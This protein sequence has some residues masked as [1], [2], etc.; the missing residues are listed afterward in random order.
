MADKV[1]RVP[2]PVSE[3]QIVPGI[4]SAWKKIFGKKPTMSQVGK[5]LAQIMLET[6]NGKAIF[7]NNVG[8]INWTPGFTGNYY[9]IKDSTTVG[10]NPAN[11]Q[12]YTAKMR[13][14]GSISSGIEDYLILLK[15]RAPVMQALQKGNI[16][17]FSAALASVHYYDPHIRDDYVDKSGKKV[18]G[19]TSGLSARYNSFMEKHKQGVSDPDKKQHS[20][21][22][23]D[24][25]IGSFFNRLS[26]LLDNLTKSASG[27]NIMTINKYGEEYPENSFLISIDTNNDFST[28][29]EFARI[30][31]L[32]L[33]EEIDA[34]SDIY[35]D[36]NDVE[37]QCVVNA[38]KARSL[39]VVKELC[40]AMSD[41][42]DY[43][44]KKIGGVK[45]YTCVMPDENS[46]YQKLD[47]KI[48]ETNYRIFKIKFAQLGKGEK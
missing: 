35:T 28:K 10:N 29:L 18:S 38:E 23:T 19:Y 33:K 16:K 22:F 47:I 8:N 11:R 6:G 1:N 46:Y 15:N 7:N 31:S 41:V 4:I 20:N 13:S 48:A 14:Y 27:T 37:V 45:T 9:E 32:A 25:M 43:A 30:L 36:G 21:S 34:N 26:D 2:T 12:Y 40:N 39:S 3:D 44:T 17:D 24:N 42:F 5:V